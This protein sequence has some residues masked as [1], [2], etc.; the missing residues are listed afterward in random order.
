M[1]CTP[2]RTPHDALQGLT[3]MRTEAH[4]AIR[5]LAEKTWLFKRKKKRV[6]KEKTK[7]FRISTENPHK[8]EKVLWGLVGISIFD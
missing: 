2:L 3:S 6:E 4:K 8:W 5:C 1:F 7:T